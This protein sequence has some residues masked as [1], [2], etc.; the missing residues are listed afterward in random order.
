VHTEVSAIQLMGD[1]HRAHAAFTAFLFY[2]SSNV[3]SRAEKQLSTFFLKT[4]ASA[5]VLHADVSIFLA[6]FDE[7]YL[8]RPM[9]RHY[10]SINI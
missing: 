10:Q 9:M 4:G 8:T 5:T 7:H 2:I 1:G 6:V 3:A